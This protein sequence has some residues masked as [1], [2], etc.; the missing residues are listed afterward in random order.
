MGIER[1]YHDP[2]HGAITLSQADPVEALL[3]RL[4]DTPAMQRLRRIR[5][6]GPASLTFH[7]A[8]TSRFTHS[9]G[10]MAIARRAFD[11]VAETY[12]QLQ[13]Y[14]VVVLCAALL[15]D[16]GHGPFSHTAEEIFGGNHERWTRQIISSSPPVRQL[17]DAYHSELSSQLVQVFQKQFPVP[18]VS[19]LVSSQLDCD[20]LDYLMRDSY[21][22]GASYG[23]IDLDR[24]I[25]ALRYDPVSQQ[26]VVAKKG[27]AAIEHYLIVRYFMYAQI[28]NHAKNLAA[29]W[30]LERLFD[31]ARE[32]LLQGDLVADETVTAWLNGVQGLSLAQYLAADD[33][34]VM[35]HL[36]C[37]QRHDDVILADLCRRYRDRDIFKTY[38]L[39]QKSDRERQAILAQVQER[40]R[41]QGYDPNYY[42]GL[43]L[44]FSRG[45][46]LYQRGINLQM[47]EGL[48]DISELSP[49]VKTLSQPMQKA[50]LIYPREVSLASLD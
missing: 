48:Q 29:T 14:R 31:R 16:V 26:L 17:L 36:S 40:S 27:L 13:Q 45:Y 43:R 42:V 37:W 1:T 34:V 23:K 19:Q 5:Q 35:Y 7:G 20:R 2:L 32:R 33:E 41:Q 22:T 30:I 47:P 38:D 28:Y 44:A 50:W 3:I 18:L 12:P 15:H 11:R 49:L 24:I 4:I 46:T 6:L 25:L 21:F 8:E 9:L 10:V 39:T